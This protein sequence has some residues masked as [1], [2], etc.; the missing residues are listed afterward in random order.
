MGDGIRGIKMDF[1]DFF[2]PEQAQAAYLRQIAEQKVGA[3]MAAARSSDDVATLK[4][5]V[6]F[7]TLVLATVIKRLAETKTMSLADLQDLMDQVDSSDGVSDAG[8]EPGV[9]RGMLGVLKHDF[10][11]E[12]DADMKVFENIAELHRRYRT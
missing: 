7:L 5:D 4:S 2:F 8:L 11:S 10:S 6:R 9:L 3:G 1:F 12:A